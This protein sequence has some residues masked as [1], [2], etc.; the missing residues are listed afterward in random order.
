MDAVEDVAWLDGL[1]SGD[2][3]RAL[4]QCCSSRRWARRVAAGRP[5]RTCVALLDAANTALREMDWSDVLEALSAHPMIGRRA[6]GDSREAVWSRTEQSG[7]DTAGRDVAK[8]LAEL[9]VAYQEKFGH[10]FLICASGLP[11][12]VMLRALEHRL[13][14]DAAAERLATRAELTAI[15]RLRLE[16]LLASG[17]EAQRVGTAARRVGAS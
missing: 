6:D 1:Q 16:R 10:V 4:S 11:A 15:T 13:R 8:R 9:N 12:E 2:A 7:M 14:N 3:E 17:A 5:Y